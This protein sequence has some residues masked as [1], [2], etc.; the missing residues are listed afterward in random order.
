MHTT[1]NKASRCVTARIMRQGEK[2]AKNFTLREYRTWKAAE[3]AAQKW[4]REMLQV[5][6]PPSQREGR[7]SVR[8]SSGV[9]GVW[10][11]IDRR[12]S[13]REVLEYCRWGARWPNCPN[14]GGIRFSVAIYGDD[15][16][17]VLAC[18][19]VQNKSVDRDWLVKKLNRIRGKKTY[20]AILDKKVVE[21]VG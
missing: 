8:N 1:R 19:A 18:L 15:D 3:T 7:M 14:R 10:P 6:P 2:H 5:L 21:F 4:V 20:N 16:A 17:F 13:G 9:V 11:S 12:K